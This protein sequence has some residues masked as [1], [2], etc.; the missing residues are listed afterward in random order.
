M[1]CIIGR[2]DSRFSGIHRNVSQEGSNTSTF[3]EHITLAAE[4]NVTSVRICHSEP[5]EMFE[6][7]WQQARTTTGNMILCIDNS[8]NSVWHEILHS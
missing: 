7:Q 8:T 3:A 5:G 4:N 1:R 6:D 2:L